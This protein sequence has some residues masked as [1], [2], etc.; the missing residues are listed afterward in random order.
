M[1]YRLWVQYEG[2]GFAGWQLQPR[3][4]TVQGE[5]ERALVS[6]TGQAVKVLAAG[7]T[8]AGVHASGQVVSFCLDRAWAPE[9]LARALNALTEDDVAVVSADV[10]PEDFHPRKWALSRTYTYRIWN[11][12]VASPFW[13]RYAWHVAPPL[14]VAAM[15]NAAAEICGE[16]DFSAFRASGCEAAHPVRRVLDSAVHSEGKLIVY[17]IEANGFLRHMVRNIVGT[18]VEVGL[19]KR[20]PVDIRRLLAARDRKLA[21]PTAPAHGL[22]LTAVRY[23]EPLANPWVGGGAADRAEA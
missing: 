15:Q 21:G 7:R 13:R 1:R 12:R 5:L 2:T 23:L 22:C 6:L 16:H 14:D 18:L 10:V 9:V 20:A 17:R 8:D 3:G 11:D 19:G 4:R